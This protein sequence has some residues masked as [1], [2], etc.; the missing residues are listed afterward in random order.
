MSEESK[1][2]VSKQEAEYLL[3]ERIAIKTF[4]GT[5]YDQA[6][7]ESFHELTGTEH[8]GEVPPNTGEMPG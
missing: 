8:Q 3:D 5:P 7:R 2:K 1:Q 4:D 6:F